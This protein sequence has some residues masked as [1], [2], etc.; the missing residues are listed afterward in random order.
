MRPVRGGTRAVSSAGER[1]V[2]IAKVSGSI[3]LPPTILV[4]PAWCERR[5]SIGRSRL[6]DQRPQHRPNP[7][8][9]ARGCGLH[10]L[11]RPCSLSRACSPHLA[12][13]TEPTMP[14]WR[15]GC[16]AHL[17]NRKEP[18]G[19]R[20]HRHPQ[21]RRTAQS[22]QKPGELIVVVK[23]NQPKDH[24]RHETVEKPRMLA[25]L[26]HD[27]TP[28]GSR[29]R[30]RARPAGRPRRRREGCCARPQTLTRASAP[31]SAAVIGSRSR[32][33]R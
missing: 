5:R 18:S 16:R 14:R 31:R 10:Q 28:V 25:F 19:G 32:L 15:G 2:D 12:T 7:A 8:V 17:A 30:P 9:F 29:R 21:G 24:G 27:L 20:P 22:R 13:I 4:R 6:V 33:R 11:T 3:P 23:P 26:V 1:R